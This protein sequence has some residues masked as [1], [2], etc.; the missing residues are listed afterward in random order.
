MLPPFLHPVLQYFWLAMLVFVVGLAAVWRF[1]ARRRIAADPSLRQ[2]LNRLYGGFAFWLALPCLVM[3][4]GILSGAVGH[5]LAYLRFDAGNPFIVGFWL[6]AAAEDA[7]FIWWVFFRGGADRIALHAELPQHR[8]QA[9][10]IARGLAVA[11]PLSHA[12][13]LYQATFSPQL[14]Q[15]FGA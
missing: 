4:A 12:T 3:G 2:P 1:R 14:G 7:L 13:A 5:T 10:L 15:L 8:P 6:L 11:V 9:R